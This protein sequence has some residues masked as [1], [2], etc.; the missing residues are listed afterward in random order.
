MSLPA[1]ETDIVVSQDLELEDDI[2]SRGS[3]EV[4]I[5]SGSLAASERIASFL[6]CC[7]IGSSSPGTE[8]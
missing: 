2:L 8:P 5:A 6:K 4:H 7:N 1:D 3:P